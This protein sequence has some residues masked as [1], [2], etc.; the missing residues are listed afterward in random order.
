GSEESFDLY[1]S[2]LRECME[3]H[4]GCKNLR[5]KLRQYC[6][7]R[8][9]DVS[10]KKNICIYDAPTCSSAIPYAALSY[11]WGSDQESKTVHKNLEKRRNGFPLAELPRTIRDAAI[12]TQRLGLRY[13][14]VDAIC[15]IQDDLTDKQQQIAVISKIYSAASITIVAARAA[16]ADDGFLQPRDLDR[17]YGA[18]FRVK[19]HR[20]NSKGVEEI[21]SAFLSANSLDITY[22]D[23]IDARG[24]TYQESR[25]SLRNLRFGSKQTVWDCPKNRRID[26]GNNSEVLQETSRSFFT[27][28][29]SDKRFPYHP[30]DPNGKLEWEHA[31]GDWQKSVSEYSEREL[32]SITDRLTA[33]ASTAKAF[34]TFSGMGP[35]HYLAGLWDFNICMELRWSRREDTLG[36][37]WCNKRYGPTWSWSS[38]NAPI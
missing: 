35:E 26:G 37:G 19:Y 32:G 18:V 30:N 31:L 8:L 5:E 33:F 36:E 9:I 21:I 38:L 23:P 17:C 4:Q 16:T 1:R 15:I 27:G 25:R 28:T 10:D 3:Q 34:T 24:W 2:W 13:L 22:D 7:P 6:P 29:I 14:W 11:C 20:K 12:T